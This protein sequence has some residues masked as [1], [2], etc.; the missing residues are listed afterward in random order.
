M[1]QATSIEPPRTRNWLA[2]VS[3]ALSATVFC[4]TEFLPVGLLR[5]ISQG[6]HVSDGAAG[7]MVSAP[8]LLAAIAAPLLTV[9]VGRFDRRRV[10]L[11][12]GL[13]LVIS[14]LLAMLA[15][16]FAILVVARA[17]FGF[18]IG[19]FWAI[20]VG[21]GARLVQQE[22]VG[23]ATSLIFAGVSLGMLIGGPAGALIGE[24]AGWRAAFGAALALSIAA[25]LAQWVS[26]PSLH[27]SHR[28]AARDLLGIFGTRAARIGL[29]AMTLV[30]CGQ[31][32]TYTYITPFLATVSGFGGKVIS[33]L[34]LGYTVVGLAGN[35]IGGSAAQRNVKTTLIASIL[36]IAVPLAMLPVLGASRP[37]V[38][39]ALAVWGTAYGAL[40]VALQM[41]MAQATREV[42]EGGMALFVANFQISIALGSFLGGRI[43]DGFGLFNA[44]FFGVGLAVV[45]ILTLALTGGRPRRI[46]EPATC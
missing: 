11:G 37:S 7:I 16:N 25:L 34:L 9:A 1:T 24:L 10:L 35:F 5:Y 19:G 2:V 38:L 22:H 32:A 36:F 12:L 6:L 46:D 30:L 27:V 45:S 21:L 15:P 3:V 42:R 23:Q 43:V 44:M 26:L 4:T 13:L 41:W 31:F 8:G 20:S 14:N 17:L 39:V 33:S 29:I 28:V 40:P 18:A